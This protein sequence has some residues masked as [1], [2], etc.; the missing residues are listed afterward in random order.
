MMK[1]IIFNSFKYAHI[2]TAIVCVFFLIGLL[3]GLLGLDS[4][5]LMMLSY[6][7]VI[8]PIAPWTML[9]YAQ[10]MMLVQGDLVMPSDAAILTGHAIWY[11]LFYFIYFGYN[12][13]R[14]K[15]NRFLVIK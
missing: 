3:N 4:D 14:Y 1:K 6:L 2:Y 5:I 10:G 9:F 8:T 11:A 15:T 12:F 13:Y 7:G